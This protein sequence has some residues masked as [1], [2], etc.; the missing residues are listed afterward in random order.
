VTYYAE[1]VIQM[2]DGPVYDLT[3]VCENDMMK[4]IIDRFGEN[5]KTEII[6]E[7]TFAAYVTVPASPTFFA[8]VFTFDGGIK[9]TAPEDAANEYRDMACR[10][11]KTP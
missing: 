8:W 6:S 9:I 11:A 10:A 5:V 1:S 4:H 2:Y 7:E 3:L